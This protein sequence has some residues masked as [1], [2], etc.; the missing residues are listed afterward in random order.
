LITADSLAQQPKLLTDNEK[1]R[2]QY[3]NSLGM[4][5]NWCNRMTMHSGTAKKYAINLMKLIKK[6]YHLE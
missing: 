5:R 2:Q 3:Y 4:W 1:K 6:E